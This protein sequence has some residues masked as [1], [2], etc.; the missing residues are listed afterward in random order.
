MKYKQPTRYRAELLPLKSDTGFVVIRL[1]DNGDLKEK[2]GF[3]HDMQ[4]RTDSE[5]VPSERELTRYGFTL[6]DW[7]GDVDIKYKN[8]LLSDIVETIQ[9]SDLFNPL[10]TETQFDYL[11]AKELVEIINKNYNAIY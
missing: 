1:Y 5:F 9:S 3:Q 8:E 4:I 7:F 2:S 6:R 11:Q 10:R